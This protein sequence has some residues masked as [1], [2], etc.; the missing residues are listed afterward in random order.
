M[1]PLCNF[2]T[3]DIKRTFKSKFC[4]SSRV[5]KSHVYFHYFIPKRRRHQNAPKYV[6]ITRTLSYKRRVDRLSPKVNCPRSRRYRCRVRLAW[7]LHTMLAFN[8]GIATHNTTRTQTHRCS[9]TRT[10]THTHSKTHTRTQS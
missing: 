6:Y 1:F 9:Q 7:R 4:P 10:P 3:H 2:S 8:A 5:S